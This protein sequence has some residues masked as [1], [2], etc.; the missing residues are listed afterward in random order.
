M[1]LLSAVV[2]F[3]VMVIHLQ[4]QVISGKV[5]DASSGKPLEYVSLGVIDTPIGI[6][7]NEKGEFSIDVKGQS[8]KA[9]VRVSM[10]GYKAQTFSIE[11]L[12]TKEN[13]LKLETEPIQL[14][15]VTVKPF[16]GK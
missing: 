3:S 14:G 7:T 15:E 13:I 10:I 6:V 12:A 16:S 5:L 4:A 8:S 2:L 9:Q 1:K 11:N